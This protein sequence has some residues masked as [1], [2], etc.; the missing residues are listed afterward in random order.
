MTAL[1]ESPDLLLRRDGG[2]VHVT[3]NRPDT[4]NALS[5]EMV[6]AIDAVFDAVRDDRSVRV[7]VLRGAGGHFCAGGDIKGFGKSQARDIEPGSPDDPVV[8]SNARYGRLLDKINQAPQVVIAVIEGAVRGGGMGFTCTC[9]IAIA[10]A[11]ASFGL[12]EATLGVP[13]AQVCIVVAERIGLT[14]TRM[15]VATGASFRAPRAKALGLIHHV[16]PDAA[17]LDA[18]LSEVLGEVKRCAPDAV[19]ETKRILFLDHVADR[20]T[21]IDEAAKSFAR[22]MRGDEAREGVAAF[23]AKRPA[24]WTRS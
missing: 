14:Q 11:T 19:A 1:P 2:V 10:T 3:L 23:I 21:V 13:A 6:E 7:I 9:D 15:L 24:A 17:A 22:A 4:R 12:P 16:V 5:H 18:K 8:A 20:R